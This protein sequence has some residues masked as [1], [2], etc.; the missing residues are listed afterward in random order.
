MLLHI[1]LLKGISAHGYDEGGIIVV[2][3][4]I[5]RRYGIESVSH[6]HSPAADVLGRGL[7]GSSFTAEIGKA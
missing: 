3:V 2:I 1:Y 7:C 6:A 4:I 5:Q